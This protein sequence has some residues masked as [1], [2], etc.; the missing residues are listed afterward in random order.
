M[1][2]Q[3]YKKMPLSHLKERLSYNPNDGTLTWRD[4]IRKGKSAGGYV[5][6]NDNYLQLC[7]T[8]KGTTTTYQGHR[9]IWGL[10]YGEFPD[11]DKVIDHI[12]H[13]GSNNKIENL[14]VVSTRDN[15]KNKRPRKV[16]AGDQYV[17]T[18][19]IGIRLDKKTLEYVVSFSNVK[20]EERFD[21]FDSAKY[22][23]WN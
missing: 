15:S 11:E 21:D 3:F 9:I 12:D 1:P 14:R 10:H 5:K 16:K 6:G 20:S 8:Y 23:R 17:K 7:L 2:N 4:G 19:V 18:S 13:D 22:A